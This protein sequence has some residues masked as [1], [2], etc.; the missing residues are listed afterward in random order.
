MMGEDSFQISGQISEESPIKKDD[1]NTVMEQ[2]S[3]SKEEALAALE[4]SNGDLAEAIMS[5]QE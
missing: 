5:L 1:V 3:C 2:A 4:K